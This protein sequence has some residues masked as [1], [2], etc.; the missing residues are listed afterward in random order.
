MI[1]LSTFNCLTGSII[2]LSMEETA[3]RII[4]CRVPVMT[5]KWLSDEILNL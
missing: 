4:L 1:N 5:A 2:L 3:S